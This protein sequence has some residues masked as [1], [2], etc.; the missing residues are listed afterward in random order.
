MYFFIV[1]MFKHDRQMVGSALFN[2]RHSGGLITFTFT[3]KST[4]TRIAK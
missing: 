2:D 1:G 3:G 4:K